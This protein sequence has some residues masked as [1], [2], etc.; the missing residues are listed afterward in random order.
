DRASAYPL[1]MGYQVFRSRK[2]LGACVGPPARVYQSSRGATP[3]SRTLSVRAKR[4]SRPR[5]LNLST[6]LRP[7]SVPSCHAPVEGGGKKSPPACHIPRG[8]VGDSTEVHGM[9]TVQPDS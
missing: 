1:R 4:P 2:V 8:T 6:G 3:Q 5:R 7:P 9:A